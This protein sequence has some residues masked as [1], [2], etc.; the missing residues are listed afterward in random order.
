MCKVKYTD[1][2][3]GFRSIANMR[4]INNTDQ[5]LY[6]DYLIDRLGVLTD[7]YKVTHINQIVFTYV[8]KNGVADEK[9][10]LLTD[11]TYQVATHAFNNMNLPLT[12]DP[13]K[14]GTVVTEQ[15]ISSENATSIITILFI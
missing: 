14:Y 1:P 5:E 13:H 10:K 12:M 15:F 2:S 8:K 7:A 11:A 3:L 4:A 9:R 6:I